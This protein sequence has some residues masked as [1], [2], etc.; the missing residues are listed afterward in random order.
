MT[1][2]PA[3]TWIPASFYRGGTSKGLFFHERDL[4]AERAARDAFFLAA[5]GSPDPYGRQLNGMGGGISSLSKAVIIGPPTRPDADVDYTF[6]Q[7]AV[8]RPIADWKGNCG[9]L[10]SAVGPFAVDE[11]LVKAEG[12]EAL[13]RIHQV[14]T[15]KIIHARF[16][17][18]G[19]RAAVAGEYAIDGV[20]GTGARIRLDFLAPGGAATQGLLPTGRVVDVINVPDPPHPYSGRFEVSLVDAATPVVWVEAS[21]FDLRGTEGP[22]EIEARPGLMPLLDRLRRLA[23]VKMGIAATPEEVPLA[24]PRVALLAAP[25]PFTALDG[26]SRWGDSHEIATRMVSMERLHKAVPLTGALCLGV[27]CCIPGTIAHRLS[28]APATPGEIRVAHPSG[29]LAVG[30]QVRREGKEWVAESA[31]VYRTARRLMRGEV[32]APR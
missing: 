17:L 28:R 11:G 1:D 26:S 5:I 19:G 15:G 2:D 20:S 7:L 18:I 8:D 27:A 6:I 10:S 22:D 29:T 13:V 12:D 21:A 3:Q 24:I 31:V 9:N 32:A 30:A 14:N 16:P 4:P 23:G 25:A